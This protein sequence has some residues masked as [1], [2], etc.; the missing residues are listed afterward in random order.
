M[1]R[2]W[3]GRG[4][5][6]LGLGRCAATAIAHQHLAVGAGALRLGGVYVG[7]IATRALGAVL[8]AGAVA[9]W[10]ENAQHERHGCGG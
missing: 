6:G 5:L 1:G 4:G 10:H 8:G 9:A 2:V 3:I 7:G